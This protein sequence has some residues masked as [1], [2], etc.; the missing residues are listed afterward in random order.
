MTNDDHLL[1]FL[2]TTRE[3]GR[4]IAQ[5]FPKDSNA[6][7]FRIRYRMWVTAQSN[8]AARLSDSKVVAQ[9]GETKGPGS[10]FG[11]TATATVGQPAQGQEFLIEVNTGRRLTFI[12]PGVVEARILPETFNELTTRE[13]REILERVSEVKT[14]V[15]WVNVDARLAER[16]DTF[17][18]KT[19]EGSV[20]MLQVEPAA[21]RAGS[22]KIRYRIEHPD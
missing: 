6:D 20:G 13:A 14:N 22:L 5:F 16:P 2:F 10:S 15:D 4:G 17:A 1:T 9:Q 7:R 18:F 19:A 11:K 12:G 8:P 21:E 3:G